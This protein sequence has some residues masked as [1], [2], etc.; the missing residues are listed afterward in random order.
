L[1]YYRVIKCNFQNKRLRNPEQNGWNDSNTNAI[2][3]SNGLQVSDNTGNI[4]TVMAKKGFPIS[5]QLARQE[6][7]VA[8]TILYYFE[9]I[10][11]SERT[12]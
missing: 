4:S 6:D 5:G 8:G 10:Q 9:V 11:L 12:W 2:I 7:N 3:S 1:D